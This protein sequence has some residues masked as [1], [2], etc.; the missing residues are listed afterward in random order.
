MLLLLAGSEA[1]RVQRAPCLVLLAWWLCDKEGERPRRPSLCGAVNDAA[2][3]VTG[4]VMQL[5]A[6]W[7]VGTNANRRSSLS[8]RGC[9]PLKQPVRDE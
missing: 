6:D 5:R 8:K 7:Q 4:A 1:V 9:Q 2:T 3:V